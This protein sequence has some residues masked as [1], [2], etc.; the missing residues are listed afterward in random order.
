M[1]VGTGP[2]RDWAI[3]SYRRRGFGLVSPVR[4]RALLKAY[5]IVRDRQIEISVALANPRSTRREPLR[6]VVAR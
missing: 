2:P 4:E 6:S 1:L 5:W 3:R